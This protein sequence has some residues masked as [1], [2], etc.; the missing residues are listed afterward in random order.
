ITRVSELSET[1]STTI[2]TPTQP[3]ARVDVTSS[4]TEEDF[5]LLSAAGGFMRR[6]RE[7]FSPL[8]Q[9]KRLVFSPQVAAFVPAEARRGART[10]RAAGIAA[11][12]SLAAAVPAR[13]DA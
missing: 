12:L 3:Q 6:I 9:V 2:S 10:A 5:V 8:R 13:A 1:P 11:L 4:S 7:P